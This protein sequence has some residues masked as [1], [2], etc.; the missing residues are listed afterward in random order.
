MNMRDP[1]ASGLTKLLG[2]NTQELKRLRLNIG[3]LRF[4]DWLQY[5]KATGK[6]LP[7]NVIGW[8][9]DE[10]IETGDI[11]FVPGKMSAVQIYN[12]LRRQMSTYKEKSKNIINTWADYLSMANR[13]QMDTSDEIVFRV[14]KLFQRHDELVELCHQRD[15]SDRAG[16]ILAMYPHVDE[17]CKSLK[18]KYEY[19]N[20]DYIV[21]APSRVEDILLEG[22]NLHHCVD[23]SDRY[24]ERIERRESFVLFLRRTSEADKSYYTLEVE[25]NGTV[26]QKRTMYNR[27]EADIEKATKF[28][29]EWQKVVSSRLTT[30]DMQLAQESRSLRNLEF[31]QLRENRAIIHTG[32]FAGKLLVDVLTADLME[33]AA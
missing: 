32:D 33:N 11:K 10:R 14:N 20:Q 23:K 6:M 24:W 28:L 29:T 22:R 1:Y 7:D 2:I 31:A 30:E 13:L 25:P 5:E 8:F 27:Q 16:E 26:R 3:G 18:A 12:Y 15:I 4:L 9:C 19:A 21:K 17:I